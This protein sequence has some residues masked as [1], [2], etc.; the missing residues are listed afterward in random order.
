MTANEVAAAVQA[1]NA[2]V[3]ELWEAVRRFA[4]SRAYRWDG[5]MDGRAGMVLEDYLQVAFLALLDALEGWEPE[6][7]AFLTWYGLK[8][9]SGLYRGHGTENEP[10]QTRAA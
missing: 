6:A 4:Y 2:D 5:A 8:A 1:E 3:L 9:Q 7:G 10:N